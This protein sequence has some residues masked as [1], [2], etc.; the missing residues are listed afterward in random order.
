MTIKEQLKKMTK[1]LEKAIMDIKEKYG[2]ELDT[3]FL[4]QKLQEIINDSIKK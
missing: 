4:K 3:K 1:E 2:D